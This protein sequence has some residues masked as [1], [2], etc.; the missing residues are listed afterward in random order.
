MMRGDKSTNERLLRCGAERNEKLRRTAKRRGTWIETA[1]EL[2][3]AAQSGV[4]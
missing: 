3:S 4:A 1:G 2:L